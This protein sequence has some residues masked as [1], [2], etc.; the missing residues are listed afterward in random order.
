MDQTSHFQQLLRTA[1]S[2]AEP[3]RLL[4]VFAT[5]ELPRD[6][7]AA[8]RDQFQAGGGGALTPTLC[9]D[10]APSDLSGFGELLAESRAAGPPWQVMFAAGL[11]GREGRPPSNEDVEAGLNVMV[12]AIRA[13]AA[14]RFAA[15]GPTGEPLQLR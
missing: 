3:H 11:P 5:A 4:F 1:A 8:E 2:Q 6:A 7:T 10:K 12:D 9:V 15:F 14:A 13:G